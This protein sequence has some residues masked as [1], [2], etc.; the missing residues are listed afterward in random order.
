MRLLMRLETVR[1]AKRFLATVLLAGIWLLTS[2]CTLMRLQMMRCGESFATVVLG[3]LVWTLLGVRTHMLLQV[4]QCGETLLT[5]FAI[6]CL[7]IVQTQ[8]SV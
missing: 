3:T 6:K 4:A 8:V 7:P 2:M 1:S 5:H